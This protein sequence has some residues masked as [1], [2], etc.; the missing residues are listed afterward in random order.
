MDLNSEILKILEGKYNGFNA[1]FSELKYDWHIKD[2]QV[3]GRFFYLTFKDGK[4]SLDDFVDYI[5]WNTVNFCVPEK[6]RKRLRQKFI[7]TNDHR[8]I[9]ELTD[10]ARRLFIKAKEQQLTTGEPGELILF[11]L[12]EAALK[13]PQ[14]ACKMHLKTNVNMP[15]HGSDGIHISYDNSSGLLTLY[16]GE[17]KLCHQLS[18]ALDKVCESIKNFLD[19]GT[20]DPPRERDLEILKDHISI[21]N[22]MAKEEILKYFDPYEGKSNKVRESFA[23]FVGF[24][25]NV[26]TSIEDINKDKVKDYFETEYLKRIESACDLFEEKIRK[27]KIQKLSYVFF[28]YLLRALRSYG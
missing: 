9:F 7:E 15:V 27:N 18:N 13:A 10:K 5:Y 26:L 8:Y 11:I 19:D 3:E 17:S 21:D 23:C 6:E 4:V 16:W 14:I 2:I 12:L 22:D 24:D 20:G 28:Y 25:F 1:R